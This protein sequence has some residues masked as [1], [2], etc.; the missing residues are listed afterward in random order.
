MNSKTTFWMNLDVVLIYAQYM[1]FLK[2]LT[3][4]ANVSSQ[5]KG[6]IDIVIMNA[7]LE[8]KEF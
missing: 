8:S 2:I 7:D 4:V 5:S 6:E 1:T 3:V